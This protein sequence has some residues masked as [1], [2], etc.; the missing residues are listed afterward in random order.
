MASV[1]HKREG[2]P[3]SGCGI[4]RR[5]A[6][7]IRVAH[8]LH[9][10][11]Y[12]GPETIILNWLGEFDAERFENHIV[13]FRNPGA[14]EQAFVDVATA[15][16]HAVRY[17]PW[18][19]R[20]PLLRSARA[21]AKLVRELEID[22]VH[23]YNTYAE[24]V[25]VLVKW[26]TGVKIVT[27]LWVWGALGWKRRILQWA[28]RL[29]LP[30]F[31]KVTAQ[32]EDARRDTAGPGMPAEKVALL[33]SGF[34]ADPVR[35]T[36]EERA[37]GRAELGASPDDF[38]LLNIARFWPEKAQDLLI[39][40]F[41]TIHAERPEARLWLAGV[42]PEMER[43]RAMAAEMGLEPHVA[44]LGFRTDLPYV[45]ALADLQVHPSHAEGIPLALCSG[46]A[47]GIP[48]VATEVGGVP[49]IIHHYETGVL[50]PPGK[51]EAVS[52][53]VLRLMADGATRQRIGA[54]ARQFILNEYSLE[55]AADRVEAVY[56]ELVRQ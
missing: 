6:R 13:C 44:F 3:A 19:R 32:S 12:G 43:V 20:K 2:Q 24:L 30:F 18:T 53:A 10:M 45:L 41:R 17:I 40:A 8:L 7:K 34:R 49:E 36:A 16:G 26:T 29:A 54:N 1:D 33:I 42:G 28:D 38:V 50:I 15:A 31:D 48:I 5:P 37:R 4:A 46:M 23:C 21:M 39:E 9:T 11:A 22:V 56:E 14:T 51:A 25:G 27:T 52:A 47:A 55:A 35:L